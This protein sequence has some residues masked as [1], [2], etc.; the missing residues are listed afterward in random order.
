[1]EQLKCFLC[2]AMVP[3][4]LDNFSKH[5]TNEHNLTL[6]H[7]LGGEG[8]VCGQNGCTR[9]FKQFY[10]LRRHI[11][12]FHLEE[13]VQFHQDVPGQLPRVE[14]EVHFEVQADNDN[15]QMQNIR[16]DG[17]P[18]SDDEVQDEEVNLRL[19]IVK[20]IGELQCNGSVTGKLMQFI[21][22][23]SEDVQTKYTNAL[24]R[25]ILRRLTL[26]ATI[27]E[28]VVA[29][30]KNIMDLKHP[31]QGLKTL[32]EQIG[33]MIEYFGY[34]E[35]SEI[36]LGY[37]T[38]LRLDG[39]SCTYVPKQ[40]MESFQYVSIIEV[41]KMVLKSSDVREA[42]NNEKQSSE[43]ILE[44]FIDGQCFKNHPFFQKHK[45]ALRIKLYYDEAEITN[46]IGSK[47]G[48]H[49]IG[50]FYFQ[51]SNLPPH[52]NSQLNSIHVLL[53]FCYVDASKYSFEQLLRPFLM[54]L[55]K[56]ESEE[57]ILMTFGDEEYRL[58]ASIESFCGD[59]L[60]VHQVFNLLAPSAN[61]FCRLCLYNRGS[62]HRGVL[63]NG[64]ERTKEI[65]DQQV[66][67][68]RDNGFS[69]QSMT[70][71]G[72]KG[73]CCLNAS[74]YFHISNN[75]IF[76]IMHNM[77]CGICPMVLKLVLHHYIC[78][79]RIFNTTFLNGAISMFNYGLVEY[80][81]KPSANFTLAVLQCKELKLPQKAMQI[82]LLTRA[83]PFLLA[84]KIHDDDEHMQLILYLLRIMEIIFAPRMPVSL[85][86]YLDTLTKDFR[87]CFQRLFPAVNEINKFHNI[88][89]Y[90]ECI[91]WSGPLLH[92]Y[93]MRFEAKH[94]EIK[95]RA[96]N[97]HNFK[98]PPKTL[99]RISQC[100]Q[101]MKWGQGDVQINTFNVQSK[102][103]QKVHRLLSQEYLL[104]LNYR[105]D[106]MVVTAASVIKNGI[107]FRTGLF[108]ML[109]T[110]QASPNSLPLYARIEE[111]IDLQDEC[112]LLTSTCT[113]LFFDVNVNA[114]CI[115][116]GSVDEEIEF[117]EI[118]VL[119]CNKSFS[120]WV[121]PSD[122]TVY[123]SH[124]HIIL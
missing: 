55:E 59:G 84:P 50:A 66:A 101:C 123:I 51:V 10:N 102:K 114:Y 117:V 124:R 119:A 109:E 105:R 75:K 73:E 15:Q 22:E 71:T 20:M 94:Y 62:L 92:F 46:P 97:V 67:Y 53:L 70:A 122:G 83:L 17:R 37:R 60:A 21:L 36:P 74:E 115:E 63:E 34:I 35:P 110:S 24:K 48:V 29:D 38:D 112:Y 4:G 86:G 41:L 68:V 13:V 30:I 26:G 103:T 120:H 19:L 87:M 61:L 96:A 106:D 80:K 77:L 98:N 25:K 52:M 6:K 95:L 107:E 88:S 33:A 56:L 118:S 99:V 27:D 58:R 14:D 111:I 113:T 65:F 7:G 11:R 100:V 79:V 39:K 18:I 12:R 121:K 108:V 89:H 1:M 64:I 54:D 104:N 91:A 116:T 57:G 44:S 47:T 8:F 85:L 90:A 78:T 31:Y 43:G 3:G 72:L 16:D 82:W 23:S 69:Q 40:V 32:E 81:N 45:H 9:N 76:D 5:F 49:K 2:Q 28:E 93:C 42:I